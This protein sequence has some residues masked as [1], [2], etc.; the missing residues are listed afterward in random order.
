MAESRGL[1]DVYKRQ[2]LY[3]G[4]KYRVRHVSDDRYETEDITLDGNI[5]NFT[6]LLGEFT[7]PF[8]VKV[9]TG[10]QEEDL[11]AF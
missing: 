7:H 2:V 4:I 1:G 5:T 3:N 11:F 6:F 9:T 10:I 8:N